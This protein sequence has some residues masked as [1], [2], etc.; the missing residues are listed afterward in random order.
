MSPQL[1]PGYP[2]DRRID[3]ARPIRLMIVDDS[4]V[5][6]TIFG[7]L[8]ESRPE[9]RIVG[10]ASTADHALALLEHEIADIILLDVQMPGTDG[11]TAL[12]LIIEKSGGARVMIVSSACNDGA[13][14]TVQALTLGAADT[15]LK[16]S[17]GEFN[18]RFADILSERLLRIAR[19]APP[20]AHAGVPSPLRRADRSRPVACLGIGAS[21]G[22]LH[23]LSAFFG[24]LPEAFAAPVLVTQHLPASFMPYFAAQLH[25]ISGR[26]STVAHDGAPLRRGEILVA[27]GDAH[28]RL[29][30]CGADVRVRLDRAPVA[31]GCFPSVDPMFEA[32]AAIYGPTAVG[33]VLSGMGSDGSAGAAVLVEAG[34]EIL[35]QDQES[36]VVWGMPGVVATAGL[37]SAVLPAGRLA[38]YIAARREDGP[39]N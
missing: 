13:A 17:A 7:N 4:I 1:S 31:N 37:A 22:G 24:A 34:G 3:P 25:D 30:R 19:T 2:S 11:L 36:S 35:A 27:P 32:M 28:I 16:P 9:F 5:A 6:R 14:A 20:V 15:L 12:P 29:A 23:A 21:T 18:A 8:L 39:W 38:R 33:V 10:M 26:P